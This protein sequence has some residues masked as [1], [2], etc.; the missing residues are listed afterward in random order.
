MSRL[1]AT[2]TY[3]EA[4][5]YVVLFAGAAMH[6]GSLVLLGDTWTYAHGHWTLLRTALAP[7]PRVGASMTY[8]QADG[9]VL[10]F[11]G[12]ISP[13]SAIP[14]NDTWNFSA[15]TWTQL[16]PTFAPTPRIFAGLAYDAADGYVLLFGGEGFA[17]TLAYQTTL[18]DTW[19]FQGG[20][21]SEWTVPGCKVCGPVPPG[22]VASAMVYD[23]WDGYIVLFGGQ[24]STSVANF[25]VVPLSS[26]WTFLAGNWTNITSTAGTPP[27]ARYSPAAVYDSF[28]GYML[29]YGGFNG[30]TKWSDTWSFV[31]G[32]WTLLHP[33]RSPGPDYFAAAAF[34]PVDNTVVYLS[35][36]SGTGQTWLY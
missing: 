11:G 31:G 22:S 18:N 19:I 20:V 9:Y 10:L 7:S 15:G 32:V 1:A 17:P 24:N 29:L 6:A 34:D 23:A 35:G 14:V 36:T 5:G 30:T 12:Q 26:T 28:D 27:A 33:A 16:H 3:D 4:D 2:M 25:S 8:D 21:W 13:S